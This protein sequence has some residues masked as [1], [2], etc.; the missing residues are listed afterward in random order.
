[1]YLTRSLSE[2]LAAA[3]APQGAARVC[4]LEPGTPTLLLLLSFVTSAA[5]MAV[6]I[7]ELELLVVKWAE[8]SR[9]QLELAELLA[10]GAEPAAAAPAG[11][12][13]A[14]PPNHFLAQPAVPPIVAANLAHVAHAQAP[15]VAHAPAPQP[16][17]QPVAPHPEPVVVRGVCE[18]CGTNVMSNDEGRKKEGE[19]YYHAQCLRGE[20]DIC[21]RVVHTS[22]DRVRVGEGYRHRDCM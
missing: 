14:A 15:H 17:P 16:Q 4:D 2:C 10:E 21:G 12:P 6:K 13:P 9:L 5:L 1:M 19:K 20:C 11:P 8:H 22:S 3:T 18:G 7:A